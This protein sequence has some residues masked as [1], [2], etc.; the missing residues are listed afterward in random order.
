MC[1]ISRKVYTRA[2]A[3][4]QQLATAEEAHAGFAALSS[5]T[6]FAS[7]ATASAVLG[8]RSD[9]DAAIFARRISLLASEAAATF[10][11]NGGPV[12]GRRAFGATAAAIGGVTA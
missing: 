9:I 8:I 7:F 5:A 3:F 12:G 10:E 11:A 1:R 4:C 2:V 6:T